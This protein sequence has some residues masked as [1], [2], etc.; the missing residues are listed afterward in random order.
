[1]HVQ[2]IIKRRRKKQNNTQKRPFLCTVGNKPI[3]T[4]S[5]P[6][7]AGETPSLF[8]G[9]LGPFPLPPPTPFSPHLCSVS[10]ALFC[11]Y[12]LPVSFSGSTFVSLSLLFLSPYFSLSSLSAS[13]LL[14]LALSSFL[15][16]S[17]YITLHLLSPSFSQ[18]PYI[19][20][21]SS[22]CLSSFL[23]LSFSL[24]LSLFCYHSSP[25][26]FLFSLCPMFL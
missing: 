10:L 17:P 14:L 19:S 13:Q 23:L 1:M 21:S 7:G 2:K 3:P 15:C 8:P 26:S 22:L 12:C 25:L 20:L 16:A 5:E 24:F 11:L 4:V 9:K 6:M 18:S